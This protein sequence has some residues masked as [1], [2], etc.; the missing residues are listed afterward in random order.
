MTK[1]LGDRLPERVVRALDGTDLED[2]IGTA[3][4]LVSVDGDGLP[5]VCMLSAGEILAVDDRHLRLALWPKTRTSANLSRGGPVLL[6][7]VERDTVLYIRGA[8]QPLGR[9][10]R[11]GVERF[12]V[13]VRSIDSDA[14]PGMPVTQPIAFSI[15]TDDPK[16]VARAWRERLDDLRD[17]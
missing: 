10:S 15:G 13:E 3:Y 1:P 12:D 2:K 7:F 4:L 16:D 6:C 8:G 14:H 9:S 17:A 11:L 5:R